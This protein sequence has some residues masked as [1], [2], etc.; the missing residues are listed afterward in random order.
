M[1]RNNCDK[2]VNVQG[3]KLLNL[4]KSLDL[5]ILNGRNKGDMHGNFT[6]FNKNTGASAIDY[7]IVSDNLM[8][9]I[10]SF[11]VSPQAEYSDHCK[12]VVRISNRRKTTAEKEDKYD[13][14]YTK[15]NYTWENNSAEIFQT[16][17]NEERIKLL[18]FQIEQYIDAGLVNS[19]GEKLQELLQTMG[20]IS[21]KPKVN[22]NTRHKI[23]KKKKKPDKIWFDKECSDTKN[24]T[25]KL[26][27]LKHQNPKD[28]DLRRK[29]KEAIK[30]DREVYRN[31]KENFVRHQ[32][33]ELENIKSDSEMFWNKWKKIGEEKTTQQ[34]ST[35]IE[36]IEWEEY[37]KKYKKLKCKM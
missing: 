37:F 15:P 18:M 17:L 34:I 8:E 21:L 10:K 28:L 2:E 22:F 25:R 14:Q 35:E 1:K 6:H 32:I 19:S 27:I 24:L 26:A 3:E 5:Q 4:C 36:G 11:H 29:H 23:Q 31:K 33:N 20:D 30:N 12:I 16:S 9:N 13:W 7:A